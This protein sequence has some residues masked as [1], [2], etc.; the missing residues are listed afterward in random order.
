M[1]ENDSGLYIFGFVCSIL[2][3]LS[4]CGAYV[5]VGGVGTGTAIL[6]AILS[7]LIFYFPKL[8]IDF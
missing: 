5:L 4:L 8:H 3:L 6:F 7:I 2:A 1:Q